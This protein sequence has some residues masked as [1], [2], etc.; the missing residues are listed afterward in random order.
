MHPSQGISQ[1][2]VF[3]AADRLLASGQE[4]TYKAIRDDLKTGSFTTLGPHLTPWK[5]QKAEHHFAQARQ[6]H[7]SAQAEWQKDQGEFLA[8]VQKLEEEQAQHLQQE[9]HQAAELKQ[10]TAQLGQQQEQVIQFQEQLKAS[11]IRWLEAVT[12]ADRLEQGWRQALAPASAA[13]TGGGMKP[14]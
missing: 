1:V 13:E 12:R 8:L 9:A 3:E 2:Q 7:Q 4:L 5:Q 10:I 6:L 11:E 14:S